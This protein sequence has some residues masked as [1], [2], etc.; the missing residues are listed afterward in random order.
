MADVIGFIKNWR[1]LKEPV[2]D[3]IPSGKVPMADIPDGKR[4][5]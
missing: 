2:P 5:E 1:Y 4:S 3:T